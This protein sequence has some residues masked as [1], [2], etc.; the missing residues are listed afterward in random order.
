VTNTFFAV[1]KKSWTLNKGKKRRSFSRH[2]CQWEEGSKSFF[3]AGACNTQSLSLSLSNRQTN[4]QTHNRRHR[5]SGF[6]HRLFP[7]SIFFARWVCL[8]LP[9]S[10]F[11][12]EHF[13]SDTKK[14]FID[15]TKQFLSVT[16]SFCLLMEGKSFPFLGVALPSPSLSFF[17]RR[18]CLSFVL[19]L[20]LSFF[21]PLF[22]YFIFHLCKLFHLSSLDRSLFLLLPRMARG[23]SVPQLTNNWWYKR[24][25]EKWKRCAIDNET[26]TRNYDCIWRVYYI[27]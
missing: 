18:S 12:L 17:T 8:A 20:S 15:K 11:R 4:T 19:S 27:L 24:K 10:T 5:S 25:D 21:L 1:N 7:Q 6:A 26:I 9:K 13:K 14:L 2:I 22:S 3:F 23:L 16:H